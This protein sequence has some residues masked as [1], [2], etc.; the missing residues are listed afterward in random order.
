MLKIFFILIFGIAFNTKAL[1]ATPYQ[2][3][4]TTNQ[5]KEF[6]KVAT[7]GSSTAF[8]ENSRIYTSVHSE[9]LPNSSSALFTLLFLVSTRRF[10]PNGFYQKKLKM[11]RQRWLWLILFPFHSFD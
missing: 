3:E 6:K 8:L 1:L 7:S 11:L 5:N 9:T 10:V 4:S 2:P